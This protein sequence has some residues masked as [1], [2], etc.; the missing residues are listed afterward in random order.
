VRFVLPV[1]GVA[2]VVLAVAAAERGP[3]RLAV[4]GALG[5]IALVNLDETFE[6]GRPAAPAFA[7][8]LAGALVAAAVAALATR[9]PRLPRAWVSPAGAALVVVAATA[10]AVPARGFVGRHGATNP[11]LTG[12][13]TFWL[14]TQPDFKSGT[15]GVETAL[16]VI[17]P[18]AGD[19]LQHP[20]AM[21]P[22]RESCAAIRARARRA[23]LVVSGSPLGLTAPRVQICLGDSPPVFR[24]GP[25]AVF[26]P[27]TAGRPRG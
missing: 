1:V 20:L 27:V 2:T 24:R 21:L 17:G 5:A 7:V 3:W 9:A 13:V 23:Y 11:P 18:L 6:L 12:P 22:R 8:P 10:L 25:Y 14:G 19:R 16:S 15:A 4:A 26:P